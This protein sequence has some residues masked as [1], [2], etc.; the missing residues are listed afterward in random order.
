MHAMTM[1][2]VLNVFYL[3]TFCRKPFDAG[4]GSI[5]NSFQLRSRSSSSLR[6]RVEQSHSSQENLL[7]ESP[8][9]YL[10]DSTT[11]ETNDAKL[12]LSK[13]SLQEMFDDGIYGEGYVPPPV[14]TSPET[15][16]TTS[17]YQRPP[18]ASARD[19]DIFPGGSE[20]TKATKRSSLERLAGG[21]IKVPS[22]KRRT[23][24]Q[25]NLLENDDDDDDYDHLNTMVTTQM[26]SSHEAPPTRTPPPTSSRQRGTTS[27]ESHGTQYRD[28]EIY[29]N[30]LFTKEGAM[31]NAGERWES[32]WR[33]NTLWRTQDKGQRSV[34]T[35]STGASS[36]RR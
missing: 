30:L 2:T 32:Y 26:S 36:E 4:N 14:I 33:T 6:R 29:G 15:S 9:L 10:S 8:Y 11:K 22:L 16:R 5:R 18:S 35:G 34:G 3:C 1:I 19:K 24:S 23:E 25:D 21:L 7:D 28:E 13:S 20:V 12:N 27:D 17:P 31:G